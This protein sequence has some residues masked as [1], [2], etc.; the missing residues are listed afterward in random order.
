MKKTSDSIANNEDVLLLFDTKTGSSIGKVTGSEN[1]KTTIESLNGNTVIV[2]NGDRYVPVRKTKKELLEELPNLTDDNTEVLQ[3]NMKAQTIDF[4]TPDGNL[5][6][7]TFKDEQGNDVQCII[8]QEDTNAGVV[9]V[10]VQNEQG[11]WVGQQMPIESVQ[12]T[13]TSNVFDYVDEIEQQLD[14]Q[15]INEQLQQAQEGDVV[16][17]D[18]KGQSYK[19]IVS[20]KKDNK[21]NNNLLLLQIIQ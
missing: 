3:D 11:N 13:N 6:F 12:A 4:E 8:G 19:G 2:D 16:E 10:L 1:G 21:M 20:I 7:G 9:N 18:Y 17:F 5:I 15:E 14:A